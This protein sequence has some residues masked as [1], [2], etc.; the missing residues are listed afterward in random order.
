M[1]GFRFSSQVQWRTSSVRDPTT[2]DRR[3]ISGEAPLEGSLRL[4]QVLPAHRITWGMGVDLAER[5]TEYAYDEVSRERDPLSWHLFAE[6]RLGDGWRVR[7]EARDLFGSRFTEAREKYDGPRSTMPLEER[8]Y[9]S[10][11]TPGQV[12]I[13]VRRSMGG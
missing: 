8:E 11:R 13:T 1:A 6:R 3:G 9:R 7:A 2:G 10:H 4:T 5:E 12:L